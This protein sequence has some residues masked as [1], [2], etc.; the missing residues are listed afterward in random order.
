M[1]APSLEPVVLEPAMRIRAILPNDG[2]DRRLLE[3]LL[4]DK[5]VTR[6]DTVSVRAVASLR[7]ATSKRGRLP[8]P[9]LAR[10][11]TVIVSPDQADEL[12]DYIF[13][14]AQVARP[15]GG[16]VMMDQLCG[17]TENR[18]PTGLPER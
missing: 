9:A 18:L 6:A 16:S 10:L 17:A 13:G 11:V 3:A 1:A 14:A 2:S 7:D 12:F 5:G 15:G 4:R 8:E